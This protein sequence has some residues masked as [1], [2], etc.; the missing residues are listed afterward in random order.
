M[1]FMEKYVQQE[2]IALKEPQ[3]FKHVQLDITMRLMV[4]NLLPIA[5][6][7]N[8]VFIALVLL[9]QDLQ[10]NVLKD[11][12]VQEVQNTLIMLLMLLTIMFFK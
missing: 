5:H 9:L 11:F 1:V 7:A 3:L 4:E 12:I 6:Y 10:E 2:D 8:Q